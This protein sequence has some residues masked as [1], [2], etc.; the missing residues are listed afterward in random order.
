MEI[1]PSFAQ[2][3]ATGCGGFM[4]AFIVEAGNDLQESLTGMA[5]ELNK[6]NLQTKPQVGPLS[7]DSATPP[8]RPPFCYYFCA[9]TS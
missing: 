2:D 4:S 6:S 8:F 3:L 1:P 9:T 7:F 5:A